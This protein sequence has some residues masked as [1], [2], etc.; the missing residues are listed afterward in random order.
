MSA[1]SRDKGARAE[2]AVVAHL[3]AHGFPYAERRQGGTPGADITGCPGIAWEVKDHKR[4]D[5]A[6]WLRQAEAQRLAATATY[7]PLIVKRAGTTDVG[8]WYAVLTVD[9]L[10]ALLAEA[11]WTAP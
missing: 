4:H 7:G 8:Q 10:L 5:L 6:G 3:R 2:R 11:G 9:Q 1:A